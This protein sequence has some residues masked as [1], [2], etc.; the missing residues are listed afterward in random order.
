[1]RLPV[2][3]GSRCWIGSEIGLR[4]GDEGFYPGDD[5]KTVLGAD[6]AWQFQRKDGRPY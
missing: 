1:M 6:G 5:L 4:R 2:A 3:P